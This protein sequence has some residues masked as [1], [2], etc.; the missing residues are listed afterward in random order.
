M[1]DADDAFLRH[2]TSIHAAT[3]IGRR[4]RERCY[5]CYMRI[6]DDDPDDA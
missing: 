6:N 2:A 1:C 4:Q 5:G 3:T